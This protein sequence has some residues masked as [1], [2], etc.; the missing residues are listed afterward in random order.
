MVSIVSIETF[1]LGLSSYYWINELR[2]SAKLHVGV[3]S[4]LL[5][6][7]RTIPILVS[8]SQYFVKKY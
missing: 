5:Q 1:L 8:S 2:L 4:G 7:A 6:H 3:G